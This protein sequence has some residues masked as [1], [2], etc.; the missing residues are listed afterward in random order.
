MTRTQI[1]DTGFHLGTQVR[2]KEGRHV[3]R[4][5]AIFAN[6]ARVVWEDS[7]WL[8]DLDLGDIEIAYPTRWDAD[9]GR[10]VRD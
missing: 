7:G 10:H 5:R 3:A 1:T 6:T 4:I 2:E 9:L 8:S